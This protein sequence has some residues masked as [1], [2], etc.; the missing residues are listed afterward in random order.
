M[1]NV[2]AETISLLPAQHSP[3]FFQKSITATKNISCKTF[4]IALASTVS[5]I[6][7]FEPSYQAGAS[8]ADGLKE[9]TAASGIG[10]NFLFNIQAYRE[11]SQQ[12]SKLFKLPLQLSAAIF[13][14]IMCVAPNLFMNIVDEEGNYIDEPLMILQIVSALLNIGVNIVGSMELINSISSLFK[15]KTDLQ[16]EKLIEKIN[17]AFEK[18][19]KHHQSEP[20]ETLN[21][22]LQEQLIFLLTANKESTSRQKISYY[23]LNAGLGLFSIPQFSAYL[24]ISYFGMRDLS[25]K[26]LGTHH[27]I[28]LL[29]GSLAAIGNGIPGAGFSIKGVNSM[30]KKLMSL[31]TPSLLATLFALPALF[32]GFTTHKAMADSLKEVGYSGNLAEALKWIANLGAALIYNLPQMLT[33]ANSLNAPAVNNQLHALKQKLKDQIKNLNASNVKNFK[34]ELP[35]KLSSFFKDYS[36]EDSEPNYP[37]SYAVINTI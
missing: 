16:K 4:S 36:A 3:N 37:H 12:F 32:S 35:N 11:L 31:Q 19:Q 13:F 1:Q 17:L 18:F 21:S 25:E 6:T 15:N 33:L 5:V 23:S 14:S 27:S 34:T 10:T 22:E 28:S 30:S 26:K 24:L 2:V 8:I 9:I 20:N 29:L 7:Y